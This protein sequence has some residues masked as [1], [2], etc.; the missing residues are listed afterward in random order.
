MDKHESTENNFDAVC[1]IVNANVGSRVLHLA[2]QDGTSG[3]TIC[4][5]KG[6]INNAVLQL[7]GLEDVRKEIV[8]MAIKQSVSDKV[9]AVLAKKLKIDK[10]NHGIAFKAPI[11]NIIGNRDCT[12]CRDQQLRKENTEM[13]QAIVTIVDQGLAE[14]VIDA[15]VSA[16]S[17]GGTVISGRGSG[18]HETTK[19]F[20][21]AVEPEKDIVLILSKGEQTETIIKAINSKLGIEEPG[22]GILFTIDLSN[23]FG[24]F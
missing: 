13:N 14:Q 22:K 9:I 15:A 3:G 23:T 2:K 17:Q 18:S 5:G 6:T 11:V 12:Y 7:F 1:F 20:S 21:M 24:L 8:I 16:G 4:Y 10:P 19:L